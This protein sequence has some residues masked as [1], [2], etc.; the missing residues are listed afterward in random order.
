MGGQRSMLALIDNL[1]KRK[2]E[3]SVILPEE[4]ELSE[5]LKKK[6]IKYF[7]NGSPKVKPKN[8]WKAI[9]A[10]K[11][12]IKI[13]KDNNIDILHPDMERDALLSGIAKLF[14]KAKMVWH[15]RLTRKTKQDKIIFKLADGI[16]GISDGAGRRFSD[17]NN[18]DIKYRTI[19]NGADLSR[20][21][22]IENKQQLKNT[23]FNTN[24]FC[25]LFVGQLKDAKG[26]NEILEAARSLKE[27]NIS[28]FFCG[29]AE[30]NEYLQKYNSFINDNELKNVNI[31]GFKENIS[32]YM[33]ASDALILASYEGVEGMGRVI[34]E[35]MACGCV[36]IGTNISGINEAITLDTGILV[37]EK[38]PVKIK[39]SINMLYEHPKLLKELSVNSIN[40]ARNEFD[41]KIHANKVMDFYQYI[42][43]G[44]N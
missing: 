37:P 31:I 12:F 24:N 44:N 8:Y 16:I 9:K 14:T 19:F 3:P 6:N 26:V 4:G 7:I 5:L 36:P 23:L 20:F 41:I 17:F 40:R 34:F 42:I 13:I 18:F 27:K 22:P 39:E 28:F 32:N 1:D 29:E 21:I 38:D 35:A 15:V 2:F 25:V 43:N 10:I 33:Q 30:N 11:G